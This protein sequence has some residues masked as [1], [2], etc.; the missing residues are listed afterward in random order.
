LIWTSCGSSELNLLFN[1]NT[2][3]IFKANLK[4]LKWRNSMGDINQEIYLKKFMPDVN[5]HV[6]EIGS[7][8]YGNTSSFRDFYNK[9]EYIGV[10]L[11]AGKMSIALLI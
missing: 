11:E 3:T 5:G 1:G 10:D 6:L 9:N 7:K 2:I 4:L 8:D